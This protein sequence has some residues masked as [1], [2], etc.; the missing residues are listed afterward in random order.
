M[1]ALRVLLEQETIK[2]L[3]LTSR[4]I[5]VSDLQLKRI[6]LSNI[7]Q[8]TKVQQTPS[9]FHGKRTKGLNLMGGR[10]IQTVLILRRQHG[11]AE[12]HLF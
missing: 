3:K 8:I 4:K 11:Q 9:S 2:I 5:R 10:M 7:A 6:C 1:L 12:I